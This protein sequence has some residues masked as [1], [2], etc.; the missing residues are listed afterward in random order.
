MKNPHTL[1]V[2]EIGTYDGIDVVQVDIDRSR[3]FD[4]PWRQLGGY[5]KRKFENF[6]RLSMSDRNLKIIYPV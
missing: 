2:R 1:A 5:G 3:Y 4:I 6:L